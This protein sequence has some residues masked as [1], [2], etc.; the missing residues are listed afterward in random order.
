MANSKLGSVA[1]LMITLMILLTVGAV[2]AVNTGDENFFAENR[3]ALA[4]QKMNGE[5]SDN[6]SIVPVAEGEI[7]VI[8]LTI[9]ADPEDLKEI[10]YTFDEPLI[11]NVQESKKYIKEA[12]GLLIED[13]EEGELSKVFDEHTFALRNAFLDILSYQPEAAMLLPE[14]RDELRLSMKVAANSVIE[15]RTG[16]SEVKGVFFSEFVV[17]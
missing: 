12:V 4:E 8:K 9:D 6:K 7:S 14:W 10:Y 1:Y 2:Y 5:L 16:S 3:I 11:A 15:P 17:Q 13:T